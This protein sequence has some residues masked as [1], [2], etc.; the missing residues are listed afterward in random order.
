M[1]SA[2][3]SNIELDLWPFYDRPPLP[4]WEHTILVVADFSYHALFS[5][6]MLRTAG[7][8]AVGCLKAEQAVR[9]IISLHPELVIVG[10]TLDRN[11]DGRAFIHAAELSLPESKFVIVEDEHKPSNSQYPFEGTVWSLTTFYSQTDLAREAEKLI[12]PPERVDPIR[13]LSNP[14]RPAL[15]S[16]WRFAESLRDTQDHVLEFDDDKQ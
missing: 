4:S 15:V 2:R 11:E 5:A 3:T 6:Y 7:Y 13:T 9:L 14:E 8:E 1:L 16:W 10:A 12:G